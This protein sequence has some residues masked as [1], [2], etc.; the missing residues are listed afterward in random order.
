MVGK[1]IAIQEKEI[2]AKENQKRKYHEIKNW[3]I[4]STLFNI[5]WLIDMSANDNNKDMKK[6]VERLEENAKLKKELA[7]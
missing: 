3:N 2:K 4:I 5:L 6:V 7:K 1:G